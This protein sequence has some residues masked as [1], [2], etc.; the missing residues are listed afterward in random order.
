MST[1]RKKTRAQR[2]PFVDS[3]GQDNRQVLKQQSG[4]RPILL[5][6]AEGQPS[7]SQDEL[8]DFAKE[9]CRPTGLTQLG[10][11]YTPIPRNGGKSVD[12]PSESMGLTQMGYL[13]PQHSS[14]M[15]D[16][17]T[18]AENAENDDDDND[19]Q[20]PESNDPSGQVVGMSEVQTIGMYVN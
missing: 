13:P 20:D 8:S 19:M 15:D 10:Y 1:R 12:M 6:P 3:E 18:Q 2:R 11:H 14:D 4:Y 9:A 7:A 17:E 5:S 16:S